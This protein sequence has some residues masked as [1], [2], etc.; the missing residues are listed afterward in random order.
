MQEVSMNSLI[1]SISASAKKKSGRFCAVEKGR[2][3]VFK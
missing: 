3:E 2:V 1:H